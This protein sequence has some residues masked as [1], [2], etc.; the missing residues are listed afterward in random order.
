MNSAIL[1]ISSSLSSATQVTG[2][3]RRA[4]HTVFGSSNVGSAQAVFGSSDATQLR[5]GVFGRLRVG[6]AKGC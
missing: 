2:R 3:K 1:Q 6:V 5:S 4:T